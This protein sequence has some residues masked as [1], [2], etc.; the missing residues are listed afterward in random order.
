MLTDFFE[1]LL[2]LV[3]HY[4]D[5]QK[6]GWSLFSRAIVPLT[7]SVHPLADVVAIEARLLM[8]A[9]KTLGTTEGVYRYA[10]GSVGLDEKFRELFEF[11]DVSVELTLK[12]PNIQQPI[13]L[14]GEIINSDT[15]EAECWL[16]LTEEL[17][18]P[19]EISIGNNQ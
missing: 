6:I 15:I 14:T 18:D 1:R 17:K 13:K 4:L 7:K 19:L 12:L 8:D 3:K 10:E 2:D 5:K 11:A 16:S 9:L